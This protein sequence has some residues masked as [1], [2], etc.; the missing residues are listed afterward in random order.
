MRQLL[1]KVT[2]EYE[3]AHVIGAYES[4]FGIII[5]GDLENYAFF[6]VK[7]RPDG[8]E[9]LTPPI[10]VIEGGGIKLERTEGF[11]CLVNDDGLLK[12]CNDREGET[13]NIGYFWVPYKFE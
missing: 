10:L 11:I 3:K 13:V 8:S 7:G 1:K 9:P 5:E 4:G 12:T 6:V 2:L